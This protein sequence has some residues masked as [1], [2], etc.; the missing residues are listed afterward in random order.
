M[1]RERHALCRELMRNGVPIGPVNT[2][3]EAF[4]QAHA[5]HREMK[6]D[7][8]DYQGIGIP[9]R[10]SR[11]PGIPGRS[12]PRLAQHADEILDEAGFRPVCI[13]RLAQLGVCPAPAT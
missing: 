1:L 10:L 11:T 2:V 6:V 5:V 7:R 9:T 4:A 12:P 13:E 8:D 3:P